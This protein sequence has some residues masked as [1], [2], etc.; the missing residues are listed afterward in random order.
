MGSKQKKILACLLA[1]VLAAGMP[2]S[3]FGSFIN[4]TPQEGRPGTD[5]SLEEFQTEPE[6]AQFQEADDMQ[7]LE[8]GFAADDLETSADA[9]AEPTETPLP[10]TETPITRENFPNVEFFTIVDEQLDLDGNGILSAEEKAAVVKLDISQSGAKDLTGIEHFTNLEELHCVGCGIQTVDLSSLKKLKILEIS[11][12]PLNVLDVSKLTK[13]TTLLC[14]YT[15]LLFVDVQNCPLKE[16]SC[17]NATSRIESD[18]L[19]FSSYPGITKEN[20]KDLKNGVWTEDGKIVPV[21]LCTPVTY[22]WT[23]KSAG[24][25]AEG[26]MT[27]YLGYRSSKDF[28]DP[29]FNRVIQER[30]DDGAGHYPPE[31]L[32]GV[33]ELFLYDRPV[34][35]LTGIEYLPNLERLHVEGAEIKIADLRKNPALKYVV[36]EQMPLETV[37]LEGLDGLLELELADTQVKNVDF[38]MFPAL[39]KFNGSNTALEAVDFSKNPEMKSINLNQCGK[40]TKINVKP[41]TKLE[42]FEAQG[43]GLKE[44]PVTSGTKLKNLN[45]ADNQLSSLDLSSFTGLLYL[46]CRFNALDSMDMDRLAGLKTKLIAPQSRYSLTLGADSVIWF[47]DLGDFQETL[48]ELERITDIWGASLTGDGKGLSVPIFSEGEK[49]I[50]FSIE[51]VQSGRQIGTCTVTVKANSTTQPALKTPK[52]MKAISG[53]NI[54]IVWSEVANAAGYRVYR[55]PV[56]T[57]EKWTI[58]ANVPAGT[59]YF[60]HKKVPTDVNYTFTVRAKAVKDGKV[61]WS[62]YD[63]KGVQAKATLKAAVLSDIGTAVN[64]VISWKKVTGVHGYRVYRRESGKSWVLQKEVSDQVFSYTDQAAVPGKTYIY[65]VRGHKKIDGKLYR[66]AYDSKGKKGKSVL[67]Q[68]IL[69][70]VKARADQ[71][72]VLWEKAED[73]SGYQIYTANTKD[74]IYKMVQ[75]VDRPD[76]T[77]FKDNKMEYGKDAYYKVRCCKKIGKNTYYGEF[78]SPMASSSTGTVEGVYDFSEY[79]MAYKL[80][81]LS[82]TGFDRDVFDGGSTFMAAAYLA[83]WDGPVKESQAPYPEWESYTPGEYDKQYHVQNILFL[84]TRRDS[85]DNEEIK[86]AVM[87]YGG[88]DATYTSVSDFYDTN[89]TCYCYKYNEPAEDLPEGHDITIVGWDDNYPKES[90][91]V[92]PEGDGAFLCKNSWSSDWGNDGFFYISYYDDVLAKTDPSSVYT[93]VE[94]AGNY[95]KI[96]QYDPFGAVMTAD[97]EQQV[98]QANVFPE[99]NGKLAAD[100]ELSAVSF[101]TYDAGYHYE[102]YLVKDFKDKTSF[103]KL[104]SPVA[105]GTM[106]YAG[107]HTVELETP[108]LLEAGSRFAVVV[109]LSGKERIHAYYESPMMGLSSKARASVGE[110]FISKDGSKWTDMQDR[111]ENTNACIKAFTNVTGPVEYAALGALMPEK[112]SEKVYDAA[113]VEALGFEVNEE[114]FETGDFAKA[115]PLMGHTGTV[116]DETFPSVYSLVDEGRVTAVKSQGSHSLCWAFGA[117]GSLESCSLPKGGK[118]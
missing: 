2:V 111:I 53:G 99:G 9:A 7:S 69:T 74:D 41:C 50:R 97:Y 38:S 55:R 79:D 71:V 31:A 46:D 84:P 57:K 59:T 13:L 19:D 108:V 64:P 11:G 54:K 43:C 86:K 34:Q 89:E 49:E 93:G 52:L 118:G 35:D 102:I 32:A 61:Y 73:V 26:R 27:A 47:R 107:Y 23:E 30:C 42:S 16:F 39:T 58:I 56:G 101:Y 60:Y 76:L 66:G 110:T 65:T 104:G 75:E 80:S 33:T 88:V 116:R 68:V 113:E 90:F 45:L 100:E 70:S 20:F 112:V 40:L 22:V 1:A 87:T 114:F 106:E 72:A 28:P 96:Y 62:G 115:N 82:E 29:E 85:L 94:S 44:N 4:E 36:L 67:P 48:P 92:E 21:D 6:A 63:R 8:E 98:Y 5:K 117:Y 15:G 14:D 12:N 37:C 18:F 25:Q 10:V 95:D 109:K 81:N 103:G 3:A 77:V 17:L 83:R 51:N 91:V 24:I 105:S 78:S